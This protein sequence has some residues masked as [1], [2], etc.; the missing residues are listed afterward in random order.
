KGVGRD[1]REGESCDGNDAERQ[2]AVD[3]VNHSCFLMLM[4]GSSTI[5]TW[6]LSA[7]LTPSHAPA[8]HRR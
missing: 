1:Q 5:R 3:V 7:F 8:M 4:V 6:I 2:G